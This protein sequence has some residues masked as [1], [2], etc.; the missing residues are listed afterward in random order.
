M[1]PN[2]HRPACRQLQDLGT[3]KKTTT[4]PVFDRVYLPNGMWN[5]LTTTDGLITGQSDPKGA[6]SLDG[7]SG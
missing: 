1:T 5:T 3:D 6:A 2:E 4:V 7:A